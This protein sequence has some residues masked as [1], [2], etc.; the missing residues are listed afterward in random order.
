VELARITTAAGP[1]AVITSGDRT[2]GSLATVD[3]RSFD[4]L[5]ALLEA[6][7]GDTARIEPGAG[8][9]LEAARLLPV[10]GLPRKIVC[11]GL[12]YRA[13][14][15]ETGASIPERPVV[16]PKWDNALAGPYDDV[17]LP[18]ESNEVDWEAE[19]AFVFGRRCR[20]V[21]AGDAAS[22]VFGFTA[23][24]DL[25]MRDY[26]KATSQWGPGK[27]WD[28]GTAVGPVIVDTAQAGGVSP[29]LAIRGRRNGT[30]EQ[31]SRTDDLIF[32]VP[33]LVEFLTSFMTMEPGDLVLTGT[34]SGVGFSRTP[35]EF[36]Q[37]GDVYEVEIEGIGVLRNRF[38]AE[39][40][41]LPKEEA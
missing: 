2:S 9:T 5:P 3:G 35:P 36:L 12:N 7:G 29:D 25:S 24:N 41:W 13:H 11:I 8:V 1:A 34:P 20:R 17:P 33:A 4:D 10:V 21:Q 39:R 23:A 16:F 31:D 27:T 22:V 26:Q 15:A 40:D 19:L 6:A 18:E 38:V 37:A 28:R 30:V 14:A 32:G